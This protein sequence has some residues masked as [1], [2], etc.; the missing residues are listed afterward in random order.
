MSTTQIQS[1]V[2]KFVAL[3]PPVSITKLNKELNF[4]E[5]KRTAITTLAGSL[6]KSFDI[7]DGTLIP[8]L[9]RDF[10]K[11]NNYSLDFPENEIGVDLG[12]IFELAK[13]IKD[14]EIPNIKNL[15]ESHIGRSI[16]SIL[17]SDMLPNIWDRYYV[18]FMLTKFEKRNLES[19]TQNLRVFHLLKFV[20]DDFSINSKATLNNILS[21]TVL[22]D[23]LFSSLPKPKII[24]QPAAV[25]EKP[26]AE[27][28]EQYK[29]IWSDLIDASRA[30]SEV[31]NLDFEYNSITESKDVLVPNKETGKET[32]TKLTTT[33]S[34]LVVSKA[35]YGQLHENSKVLLKSLNISENSLDIGITVKKLS[36]RFDNAYQ[37]VMNVDDP[38][39]FKIMPK[40]AEKITN[41]KSKVIPKGTIN[42]LITSE[43]I[44]A[45][46]LRARGYIKP[47]G[48]GDLKVV[49]QKLKKY[50]AGEVA[51][52]ENVLLGETKERKHR[53]LDRTEDIF[54]ITNETD[55]ETTKDTQTTERFELKKESE[56]TLQE[57]MSVQAG[58]T[59]TSSFGPVTTGAHGDFA[60]GTS[61]QES[62]KNSSN[63]AR[64]VID[65]AVSKIQKKTK[66]ERTTKK[67]HEVEEINTHG[68][69]NVGGVGNISGIYR[70]VDKIYDAQ[71]YNYG[72]RLMFEF[73]VPEPSAFYEYAQTVKE[74]TTVSRPMPLDLNSPEEIDDKNYLSYIK[75][76]NVQGITPPPPENKTVSTSIVKDGMRNDG[77]AHSVNVKDLV[78]P[79]GYMAS[80]GV[81]FDCSAYHKVEPRLQVI[82]GNEIHN[83]IGNSIVNING[84]NSIKIRTRRDMDPTD[85]K[86]D[87]PVRL[88]T[89]YEGPVQISVNSYDVLSYAINV[90]LLVV[91]TEETLLQWKIQVYEKIVAS[92]NAAMA[93]YEQKVAAQASLNEIAIHGQNPRINREIEQTELKKHC[94][95]ML[96]DPRLY[97]KFD[98]MD[99]KPNGEPVFSNIDA[100]N[101]GKII[102]F[103]EQAFEWQNLTYLFFPYFW[104]KH[105]KWIHKSKIYDTDP[106]FTKFLQSGAARVVIPVPLAYT[107]AILHYIET[108]EIWNGGDPP[109]LNDPLYI[110]IAEEFKNQTDDLANA[111]PEGAAWEVT[112]PTTLVWL[113]PDMELP[114]FSQ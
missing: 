18:F 44:L 98:S 59:V 52:I 60:Y 43:F 8:D 58:V 9:I 42:P 97:G 105:E 86:P 109:T 65:K 19:L 81:W 1:D 7:N 71:I 14:I 21:A 95:K 93:E 96:M 85:P 29:K 110:S 61:N 99:S 48:V 23:K 77:T 50:V 68:F 40:E 80:K 74:P 75:A 79:L 69:A 5:D 88:A 4:I 112:L 63:F 87:Y 78:V 24:Q 26:N 36:A 84:T 54:T 64:E 47:L 31:K 39:F 57:Q 72:K 13:S 62:A 49:K 100:Y 46:D 107:N 94:L 56:K 22:V 108:G 55:E 106:L 45:E 53:V 113:Q 101:E 38:Y 20:N 70:W 6:V 12:R 83:L 10:I 27:I 15:I 16:N 67:L 35:A 17:D 73:I 34:S 51:H 89:F 3:R 66:E 11:T 90:H 37:Q 111:T 92:Y 2:F 30:I 91:R 28:I 32:K 102:Q 103:F 114:N 104:S 82:I 33:R 25:E 76:Y 41:L